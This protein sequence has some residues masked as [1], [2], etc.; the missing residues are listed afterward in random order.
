MVGKLCSSYIWSDKNRS[1][2][3]FIIG[4]TASEPYHE[5]FF[6]GCLILYSCSSSMSKYYSICNYLLIIVD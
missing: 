3:W 2:Y 6:R 1:L 4:S 5:S